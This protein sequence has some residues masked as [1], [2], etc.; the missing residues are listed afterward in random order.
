MSSNAS[1]LLVILIF[2]GS[3]ISILTAY[4]QWNAEINC[5]G[6]I[7]EE[8]VIGEGDFNTS[9]VTEYR[10]DVFSALTL[11]NPECSGVPTWVWLLLIPMII[12]SMVIILPN[13]LTGG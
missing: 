10:N 9:D 7:G 13:W 5:P 1:V 2:L 12:V 8:I 6:F 3:Y 11:F 4:G